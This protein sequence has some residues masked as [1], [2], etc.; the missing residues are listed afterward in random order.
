MDTATDPETMRGCLQAFDAVGC[1]ELIM[2]PCS[3][4]PAQAD[5]PA[6]AAGL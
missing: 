6:D 3:S 1:G 4:D 5:L 2:F